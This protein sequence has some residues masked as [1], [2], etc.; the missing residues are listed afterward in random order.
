MTTAQA[1]RTMQEFV[2][3]GPSRQRQLE[4]YARDIYREFGFDLQN[5]A[6]SKVL[7]ELLHTQWN[8]EQK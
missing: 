7:S 1:A 6:P 3:A 5:D 2:E 4:S 8:E